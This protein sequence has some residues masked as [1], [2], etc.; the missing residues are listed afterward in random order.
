[1]TIETIVVLTVFGLLFAILPIGTL[2]IKG[3]IPPKYMKV[4]GLLASVAVMAL[5]MYRVLFVTAAVPKPRYHDE[6]PISVNVQA[7]IQAAFLKAV[8]E[9]WVPVCE[10]EFIEADE[11]FTTGCTSID[12]DPYEGEFTTMVGPRDENPFVRYTVDPAEGTYFDGK[13]EVPMGK[14]S[15]GCVVAPWSLNEDE[16]P[17]VEGEIGMI[18]G[19]ELAHLCGYAHAVGDPTNQDVRLHLMSRSVE[20]QGSDVE[21]LDFGNSEMY[22]PTIE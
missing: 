6:G 17:S 12:P 20:A 4:Y 10:F 9:R 14:M 8:A 11:E 19:H 18:W 3:S 1:M 7:P 2:L 13:E 15:K 16:A 22:V 21:G 5:I